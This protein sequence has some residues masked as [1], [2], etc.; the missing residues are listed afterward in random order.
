MVI[1]LVEIGKFGSVSCKKKK[2]HYLKLRICLIDVLP[3]G[4]YEFSL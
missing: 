4:V 3:L 2:S 1:R